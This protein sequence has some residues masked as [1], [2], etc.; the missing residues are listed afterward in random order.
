MINYSFIALEPMQLH[1]LIFSGTEYLPPP[2]AYEPP[3]QQQTP[4]QIF[5][6]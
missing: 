6:Q 5:Q 1:I 2:P 3:A 4:E